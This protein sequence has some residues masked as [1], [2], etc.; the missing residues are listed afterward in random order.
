MAYPTKEKAEGDWN[1]RHVRFTRVFGGHRFTDEE[2]AELLAGKPISFAAKSGRTG[3]D[4][5][6]YGYLAEQSF[7]NDRGEDIKYV[8]FK[9]D[10]DSA[11]QT[12]PMVFSGHTFTE[13]ER[14]ALERGETIHV[15]G[16]VSKRTGNSYEADISWGDDPDNPGRKRC[17]LHF[18]K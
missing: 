4:Y 18:D 13:K 1:G 11:P 17:M 15:E 3:N 10:F 5:M 6:A 14:A 9:L 7:T 12:P 8:G 2:V 16:L